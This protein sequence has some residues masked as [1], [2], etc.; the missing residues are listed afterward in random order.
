MKAMWKGWP[1]IR[2]LQTLIDPENPEY[3]PKANQLLVTDASNE[4]RT[5]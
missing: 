2:D 1:S 5:P 3:G 4:G